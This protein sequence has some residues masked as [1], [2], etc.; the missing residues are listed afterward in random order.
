FPVFDNQP[1][2]KELDQFILTDVGSHVLDVARFLFGDATSLYATT[3]RVNPEIKGEDV[4]T[5]VMQMGD[6]V[7]V[8]AELSYATRSDIERFPETFAYIEGSKGSL[9]LETDFRIRETTADGTLLN[10]YPP[11][12][13]VWAD[14]A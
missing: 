8:T 4:A 13:Y 5:C 1:F 6:G 14:P 10:R 2:L 3:T 11:P 9:V 7:T 12:R